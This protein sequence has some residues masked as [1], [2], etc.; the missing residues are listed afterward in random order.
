MTPFSSLLPDIL[1]SVAGCPSALALWALRRAADEFCTR[2]LAWRAELPAMDVVAEY[3]FHRL[4]AP[5][6]GRLV[7][8]LEAFFQ[9]RRLT[10][11]S[12]ELLDEEHPGWAMLSPGT[13][14]RFV[15]PKAG[16]L[17][18]VPAPGFFAGGGLLVR[19]ALAPS[20]QAVETED[21]LLVDHGQALVHGALSRLLALSA[22]PWSDQ[23]MAAHHGRQFRAAL[24]DA[25]AGCLKGRTRR[26]LSA[27]PRAFG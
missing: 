6:G 17:R 22:K 13:P 1:P 10:P 7:M 9:G 16:E 18:L 20:A 8:V 5:A 14:T 27:R 12:E 3:P 23:A 11:A 4:E 21:F 24:A 15:L 25:R 2:T 26:S 19:V